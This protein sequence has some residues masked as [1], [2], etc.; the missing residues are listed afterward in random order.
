MDYPYQGEWYDES[1][2][3]LIN[4]GLVVGGYTNDLRVDEVTTKHSFM[5]MLKNGIERANPEKAQELAEPL[6]KLHSEILNAENS[7]ITK[8]E[9]AAIVRAIFQ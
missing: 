4:Y 2:Q 7:P 1:I 6:D 5:N 9:A 3:T 8:D